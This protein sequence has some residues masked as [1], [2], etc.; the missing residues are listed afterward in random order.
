MTLRMPPGTGFATASWGDA[1]QTASSAHQG[2]WHSKADMQ[3]ARE[4]KKALD[5]EQAAVAADAR[6]AEQMRQ[7]QVEEPKLEAAFFVRAHWQ[8]VPGT[9]T[10]IVLW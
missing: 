1:V 4:M 3:A 10:D 2:L 9:S 6:R 5:Q 8:L 7:K